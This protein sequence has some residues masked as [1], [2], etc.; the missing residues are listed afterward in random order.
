MEYVFNK[1]KEEGER[2]RGERKGSLSKTV[3]L[4][5]DPLLYG[6]PGSQKSLR[7]SVYLVEYVLFSCLLQVYHTTRCTNKIPFCPLKTQEPDLPRCEKYL[8]LLFLNFHDIHQEP[9]LAGSPRV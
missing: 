6:R 8:N 9:L 5:G 3:K 1:L 4:S 2:G 7:P